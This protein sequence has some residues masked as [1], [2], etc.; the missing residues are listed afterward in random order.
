MNEHQSLQAQLSNKQ[1]HLLLV[2]EQISSYVDEVPLNLLSQERR[3]EKEIAEL[4]EILRFNASADSPYKGLRFYDV[5]DA[6]LFFGRASLTEQLLL[7]LGEKR[8]LLLVGASGS[9][10][11]SLARAGLTAS[12]QAGNGTSPSLADSPRWDYH[13]LTPDRDPLESLALSLTRQSESVTAALTLKQDL[14]ASPESLHLFCQRELSKNKRP[15]LFLLVDQFEELFTLCPN[16]SARQAFID[17]LLTATLTKP[18]SKLYLVI[19]LRADFYANC[20]A[21][22]LLRQAL[23]QYQVSLGDLSP[24]ELRSVIEQPAWQCGWELEGGLVET[25]LADVQAEPGQLPLLSHAMHVTWLQRTARR[26]TVAGYQASGGVAGAIAQTAEQLYNNLPQTEQALMRSIFMRLTQLGEGAADTRRRVAPA[27]LYPAAIDPPIVQAL[28]DRLTQARLLTVAQDS[29]DVA[30][31]AVIRVWQRLRDW[32]QQERTNLHLHAELTAATQ[33]WHGSQDESDLYH[34]GRLTRTQEWVQTVQP[35]LNDAEQ[36]FLQASQALVTRA[37]Q[38]QAMRH[39]REVA[40]ARREVQQ[41][42]WRNG[43]LLA[44]VFLLVGFAAYLGLPR[45]KNELLLP[46]QARASNPFVNVAGVRIQQNEVSNAEYARCVQA[47]HCSPLLVPEIP[48]AAQPVTNV[49]FVQAVTYCAWLNG[50]LPTPTEYL[51]VLVAVYTEQRGQPLATFGIGVADGG[52]GCANGSADFPDCTETSP[53][54]VRQLAGNAAEWLQNDALSTVPINGALVSPP[55]QP[56]TLLS[57]LSISR[58]GSENALLDWLQHLDSSP[59][60]ATNLV[61]QQQLR[62]FANEEDVGLRC[63]L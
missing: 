27:E 8:L 33:R 9:G 1:A 42:R 54:Q 37:E 38:E 63:V 28:L 14:L 56:Y 57:S 59:P 60:T 13:L 3:L 47:G 45:L 7:W 29:V 5:A 49:D 25:I 10:K 20:L 39:A 48:I 62:I 19:T 31:E 41:V 6:R 51:Q 32:L 24:A 23:D 21:Y 55:T 58:G 52:L 18:N 44:V 43:L 22:P 53:L 17:N 16:E 15:A 30:H 11:S 61:A 46:N 34:G 40:A 26:L 36:L 35:L 2:Q 4:Q 50:R 12:L